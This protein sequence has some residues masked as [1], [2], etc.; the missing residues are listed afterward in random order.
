VVG[1]GPAGL[2]CADV[3]SRN[4]ISVTVYD[5]HPEIGGLLVSAFR[6]S[7]SNCRSCAGAGKCWKEAGMLFKLNCEIGRDIPGR[8]NC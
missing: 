6:T 4:G 7:N 2:A 3:L 1:A 5:R 8:T